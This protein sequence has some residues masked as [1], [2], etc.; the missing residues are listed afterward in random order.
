MFLFFTINFVRFTRLLIHS[1]VILC[2]LQVAAFV[3]LFC[4]SNSVFQVNRY[5]VLA[6][7]I[8]HVLRLLQI[9]ITLNIIIFVIFF[10]F[11]ALILLRVQLD[12]NLVVVNDAV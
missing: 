10:H 12:V 4:C 1:V 3:H 8:D 7:F 11:E 2:E 6:I 9:M 5:L